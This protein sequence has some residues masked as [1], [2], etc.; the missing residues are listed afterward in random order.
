MEYKEYESFIQSIV[1]QND[2]SNFK[3]NP[4]Y[5]HILEHVSPQYGYH[6]LAILRQGFYI[7]DSLIKMFGTLNDAIGNPN[8]HMYDNDI[9]ISPTSLRYICHALLILSHVK[10]SGKQDVKFVEIGCGYGG[11]TCAL[12]FFASFMGITIKEFHH[13]DLDSPLALQ[14][15]YLEKFTLDTPVFFHKASQFGADLQG[16][17]YFLISNYCFSEIEHEFQLRYLENLFPKCVHGFLAWNHIDVYDL[18]K[19]VTVEDEYPLTG[20]KNKYVRF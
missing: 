6:Y 10:E 5:N 13:I 9:S 11:L 12:S 8:K 1:K 19:S 20:A 14:Q 3:S 15:K 18:G 7:P 2:L 16:D 17:S 4:A